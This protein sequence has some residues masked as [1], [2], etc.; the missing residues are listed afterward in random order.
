V[1]TQTIIEIR[2]DLNNLAD[3][4]AALDDIVDAE[5]THVLAPDFAPIEGFKI[6]E[7][8]LTDGSKVQS[9][10]FLRAPREASR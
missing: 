7:E 9:V 5:V 1:T 10:V 8:T 6:I 3:L 2:R 4:V